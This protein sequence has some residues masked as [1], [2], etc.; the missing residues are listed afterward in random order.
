MPRPAPWRDTLGFLWDLRPTIHDMVWSVRDPTPAVLEL[1]RTSKR[2]AAATARRVLKRLLPA[3]ALE[4]LKTARSLEPEARSVYLRRALLRMLGLRRDRQRPMPA[5]ARHI[6]FICHG[7]IIRSPIAE[8]LF[9]RAL[10][11]RGH[12]DITVGSAGLAAKP[13]RNA[14]ERALSVCQEFGVSLDSHS[15]SPVTAELIAHADVIFVM[16][17]L[18]EARLLARYPEA[19][20]KLFLLGAYSRNAAGRGLEI[21]DPYDAGLTEVREC[22]RILEE[23]VEAVVRESFTCRTDQCA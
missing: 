18:N 1:A 16:D 7:N 8:A 5:F 23:C 21:A 14:D 10:K 6:L 15:A 2:I 9:K 22:Y 20:Q 13:C 17:Y 11:Q 4:R 12:T 3:P 19:A